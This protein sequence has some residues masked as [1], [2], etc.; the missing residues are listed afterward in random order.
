MCKKILAAVLM[1]AAAAMFAPSMAGATSVPSLPSG[2]HQAFLADSNGDPQ[3]GSSTFTGP[4]TTTGSTSI[5][6]SNN[7]F[8]LDYFDDATTA[9]TSFTASS[10]SVSGFPSCPVTFAP[11]GLP[12][13]GR[14]GYDTGTGT[15]KNYVNVFFDL[16]LGAAAPACPFAGTVPYTGVFSPTMSISGS[17]LSAPFSGSASG[18]LTGPLGSFDWIGTI[19]AS[20]PS[21][22]QFVF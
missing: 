22:S 10:C 18:T 7:A 17:T 5:S 15:Y 3:S 9:I 19:T 4:L 1:T 12:W 16:T 6:C 8:G 21:G 2:V 13:G 11:T 20:V 14:L